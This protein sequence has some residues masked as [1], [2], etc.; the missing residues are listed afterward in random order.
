MSDIGKFDFWARTGRARA[1]TWGS[2]RNRAVLLVLDRCFEPRA[3]NR[4]LRVRRRRRVRPGFHR[5]AHGKIEAFELKP[6][7]VIGHPALVAGA[8]G[9]CYR[10]RP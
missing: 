9:L 10:C 3:K 7:H 8:S 4:R 6:G 1:K 2:R 5:S